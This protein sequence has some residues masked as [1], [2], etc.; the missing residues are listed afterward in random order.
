MP[1]LYFLILLFLN[2]CGSQDGADT[3]FIKEPDAFTSPEASTSQDPG[4]P[5]KEESTAVCKYD[6][7]SKNWVSVEPS[8]IDKH[9]TEERYF[10]KGGGCVTRPLY[11]IWAVSHNK[12]GV[13][14]RDANSDG[15]RKVEDPKSPYYF[16]A[17]YSAGPAMFKQKWVIAFLQLFQGSPKESKM[18]EIQYQKIKGTKHIIYWKGKVLLQ[19]LS[20]NVTSVLI[21]N[22]IEG[23]QIGM[24]K[25]EGGIADLLDNF[26]TQNPDWTYLK[27][28]LP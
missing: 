14:W 17:D 21:E 3:P 11:D 7:N 16:E 26:R 1:I 12:L 25:A 4:A 22:E 24:E 6:E 23:T 28:S 10:A 8:I 13:K 20:D 27:S 15:Y 5:K 19:S 9:A 2:A 18:L